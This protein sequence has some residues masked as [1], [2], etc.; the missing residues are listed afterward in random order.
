MYRTLKFHVRKLCFFVNIDIGVRFESSRYT[1]TNI[2]YPEKPVLLLNSTASFD[3]SI[4]LLEVDH[5][6]MSKS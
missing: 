5:T 3:I 6:A 2:Y 4:R 1:M